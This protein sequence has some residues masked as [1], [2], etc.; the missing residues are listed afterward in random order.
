MYGLSAMLFATTVFARPLMTFDFD[1]ENADEGWNHKNNTTIDVRPSEP[2][3]GP[4]AMCFTI[5]PAEFAYGWIH[6][7][8]PN[9]DLSTAVGVYG[10]YRAPVGAQGKLDMFICLG[11]VG[12][13]LS[14]FRGTVGELADSRGEWLEFYVPFNAMRHERGPV[15]SFRPS[16]LDSQDLLQFLASIENNRLTSIDLDSLAFVTTEEAVPLQKRV[17][18]AQRARLLLS[19]DET[20]GA[21][22]PRLLLTADRVP[23]YRAKAMAGDECQAAYERLLRFAE[24]LLTDYNADDPLQPIYHFVETSVLEGIPWR[25]AFEN[26]IVSCSYPLEVLGAA[27][28]LTGDKR[29][30]DHGA[31][32]LVHAAHRLTTDEPFLERGFYYSR[33]FY[34]RALAFG[35]DWLHDRL[36]PEQR[37]AVQTTLLGFV[38]DIHEKSQSQGWGRRPLHRVWNWDPGLMGACGLGMLSLEG[39]TR[40][41]EKAIIFDCRRHLYDYL[42]LGIDGDGCGHEGPNY[43]GYGIGGGVE[44]IEVLRRQGRGDL[45][46]ET[47]YHLIPPWLIAETLPDGHRWNNLSDC[48]HEQSAYPVYMYACGR[49]AELAQDDPSCEGERLTFPSLLQP[50]DFLTQ[51]AEIPGKRQ[52]SYQALA[53]LMGWVWRSGPGRI[54][55]SEYDARHA[56]AHVLLYQPPPVCN[57]PSKYLPLA[58]HFRGRGLVVSRTGFNPDDVH[59]A[60]E[61]GPHAAGH[62]QSDKGTFTLRAYGA[63]LAIDSG[64]GNDG[65]PLKSSSSFGHNVVLIDGEGQPMRYHN[66]SSGHITGFHH[67]NLLDWIRVDAREAWSVRYD[68]DWIPRPSSP[69]KRADRTF[70]FIRPVLGVPPYLVVYDDIVKDEQE[71]EYTWQWHIPSTMRF[72]ASDS[73]I[74]AEPRPWEYPAFTST[75]KAP[76]GCAMFSFTVPEAGRY[77]LYG[78]VRAGGEELGKSDSFF[79][80]VDGGERLTWDIKT[81]AS[82]GWDAVMNRGE[83]RP[84]VFDLTAGSHTIRL[85]VREAQTE[86]FGWL[87]LPENEKPPQTTTLAAPAITVDEAVMGDPPF[88]R[89]EAGT[90]TGP[91]ASMDVFFVRPKPG[92]V[93]TDW[94]ETSR[95]GFHPRLWYQVRATEPHFLTIM[96]PN[97]DGLQVTK[98]AEIPVDGGVGALIRWPTA[99]D[100]IVFARDTAGVGPLRVV[101]SSAF[102]RTRNAQ[103]VAWALLDGQHLS[104]DDQTLTAAPEP[105]V[106]VEGGR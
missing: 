37:R 106:Q 8:L 89:R 38:L 81:G 31:R 92:Q 52:L 44:F 57:D 79:V 50:L 24:E 60:I 68:A 67:S 64:Y 53:A 48:G 97:R 28:Q 19:E 77:V 36:S 5:D 96:I 78:L 6:H 12:E 18:Q 33:T 2:Q 51:F 95:E 45:F 72:L 13:E 20:S 42:T 63:D 62:D 16:D 15:T 103:V 69:V 49:L 1:A 29:F 74:R 105:I 55:P 91:N 61:A 58:M 21:P 104:F 76:H 71:H 86:F 94:Y 73:S 22:H 27:Y 90:I 59:L 7:A 80:T 87:V 99:T 102:V 41:A 54:P 88:L 93:V 40:T 17:R 32:A 30:G 98:V 75:P 4:G 47:N 46:V 83:E 23:F 34:V 100:Y 43:L 70:L 56:L 65:D 14:Y 101:G 35:Y 85:E 84:H 25:V 3:A 10:Y 82:L 66:Q 11:P 9:V 26:H 39:E